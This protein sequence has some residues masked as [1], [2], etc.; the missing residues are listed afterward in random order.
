[1]SGEEKPKSFIPNMGMLPFAAM[2]QGMGSFPMGF[3]QMGVNQ[4]KMGDMPM[5]NQMPFFW[6][7]YQNQMP[8][9]NSSKQSRETDQKDYLNKR[10]PAKKITSTDNDNPKIECPS[11][12]KILS[13]LDIPF[14]SIDK[15]F[16][17][18]LCKKAL[19]QSEKRARKNK[20]KELS[21]YLN[22][23]IQ[24]IDE[25][26]L[27]TSS[28]TKEKKKDSFD[29]TEKSIN[30]QELLEFLEENDDALKQLQFLDPKSVQNKSFLDF[31]P[32]EK[33]PES[34]FEIEMKNAFRS[35]LL[36]TCEDDT[37]KVN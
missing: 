12:C 5:N 11:L 8:N 30:D 14:D 36:K 33:I 1:M 34:E 7:M 31:L 20:L 26:L 35:K 32:K 9:V 29:E 21:K 10:A 23:I 28:K 18:L 17:L 37:A 27:K 15:T 6:N 19:V 2:A 16:Y 3:P 24:K 25:K 4:N 13:E 22:N